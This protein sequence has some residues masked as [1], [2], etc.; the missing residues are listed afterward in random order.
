MPSTSIHGCSIRYEILGDGESIVL[1]PGGRQGLESVMP[2]AKHLAKNNR[3]IVWDRSNLGCS[4]VEFKSSS[5]VEL[6]CDQLFEL[7]DLLNAK[8]AYL[9]AASSGARISLR[10]ALRHPEAVRGLF[11]WLLTGGPVAKVIAQ[12]YYGESAQVAQ[13]SGMSAVAQIPFWLERIQMNPANE[14]R[15]LRQDPLVFASIMRSWASQMREDDLLVSMSENDLRQIKS[16][17]C[18]VAGSDDYGHLR[19]RVEKVVAALPFSV[20]IDPPGFRDEWLT[21]KKDAQTGTGYE[22]IPQL[23]DLISHFILNGYH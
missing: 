23:P 4:D 10:F 5:D 8:P 18:I 6:W 13:Q 11:L 15:L 22:L 1:T 7:L 12:M 17:T 21:I 20:L 16:K 3:V 2:L 19:D 9:I 14:C